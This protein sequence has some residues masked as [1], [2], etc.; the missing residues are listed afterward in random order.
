MYLPVRRASGTSP[1]MTPQGSWLQVPQRNDSDP[2]KRI[3]SVGRAEP[4]RSGVRQVLGRYIAVHPGAEILGY[5]SPALR[6]SPDF[7]S[8][9]ARWT[10]QSRQSGGRLVL[11]MN[12]ITP[13]WCDRSRI[14]LPANRA[15]ARA[16]RIRRVLRVATTAPRWC[17]DVGYFPL[18]EDV[19]GSSPVGWRKLSVAQ[20]VE[21]LR[22]PRRSVLSEVK[23]APL[24]RRCE[25]LLSANH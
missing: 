16:I 13:P 25:V 17:V 6:G 14:L 10:G 22:V 21:R 20:L 12:N 5:F 15:P 23:S 3:G 18:E 1:W 9:P 19:A 11:G 4:T 24:V 7:E 2:V 8:S